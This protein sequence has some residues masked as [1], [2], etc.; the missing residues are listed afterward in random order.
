M[1]RPAEMNPD[2]FEFLRSEI[3]RFKASRHIVENGKVFHLTQRPAQ[4]R[5]DALQSFDPE[6]NEAFAVVTRE[7]SPDDTFLLRPRGLRPASTYRVSF[8]GTS[9]VLLFTG[10]QL[11]HRGVAVD[12]PS[13]R[14]SDLVRIDPQ[15]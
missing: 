8:A 3:E 10:A 13:P 6:T 14:S 11:M 12:L 1:N 15:N 2:Q 7:Q 4:R 5:I 9:E